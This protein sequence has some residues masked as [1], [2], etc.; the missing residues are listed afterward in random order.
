MIFVAAFIIHRK[1][2]FHFE[3]LSANKL[4]SVEQRYLTVFWIFMRMSHLKAQKS[5]SIKLS[6]K[7]DKEAKIYA[8][9]QI[10]FLDYEKHFLEER[11]IE[12]WKW[13]MIYVQQPHLY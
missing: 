1:T 8:K 6:L 3:K 10:N 2:F 12:K 4:L 7:K 5:V 13:K 11:E 9:A